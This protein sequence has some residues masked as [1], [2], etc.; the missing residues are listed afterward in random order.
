L[1]LDGNSDTVIKNRGLI[2]KL[3]IHITDGDTFQIGV[4]WLSPASYGEGGLF[5]MVGYKYI[6]FWKKLDIS[7]FTKE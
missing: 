4:G 6:N 5:I 1:T 3:P 7:W 2:M